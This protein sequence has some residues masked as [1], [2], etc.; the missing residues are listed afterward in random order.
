MKATKFIVL[1]A[2]ILGILAFFLPLAKTTGKGNVQVSVSAFQVV[3]GLDAV[4]D[5]VDK[6]DVA[7]AMADSGISSS[8]AK[9]DL[10]TMKGIVMGVFA[11]AL[12]LAIVGAFGLKRG[13]FGRGA[14]A[15]ALVFGLLALGIGAI[16]KSA[17]EGDAGIALTLMLLTGIGG[18]VGGLI[19]LV[20]PDRG[21]VSPAIA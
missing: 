21:T 5:A 15:L 13:K 12:L 1:A 9:S 19:A 2:G 4:S 10:S 16:L 17:F 20:K 8:S 6:P 18:T 14:G 3:K 7:M 11:P